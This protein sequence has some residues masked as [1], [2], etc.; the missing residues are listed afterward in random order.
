[1]R[2]RL[3]NLIVLASTA[4]L[5][6]TGAS[7]GHA[8]T[9]VGDAN[10]NPTTLATSYS[11]EDLFTGLM[12][13]HGPVAETHPGLV[14]A[15]INAEDPSQQGEFVTRV[16]NAVDQQDPNFFDTFAADITSGNHIQVDQAARA[17]SAMLHTVLQDDLGMS[18]GTDNQVEAAWLAVMVVVAITAAAMLNSI[19]YVNVAWAQTMSSSPQG[20]GLDYEKWVD[21]VTTTLS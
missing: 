17:A 10:P 7:P 21:Q 20:N 4:A 1:M 13:G 16:I 2:S 18:L 8:T 12:L 9:A 5:L 19:A 6:V 11:G 15:H 14:A 3:R